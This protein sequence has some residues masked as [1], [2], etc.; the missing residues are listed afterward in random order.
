MVR[1]CPGC[2]HR[3]WQVIDLQQR[4]LPD[5]TII[6]DEVPQ[7]CPRCGRRPEQVIWNIDPVKVLGLDLL[8]NGPAAPAW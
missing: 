2:R 5:G 6:R 4:Q 1:R 8:P 7:P 3:S